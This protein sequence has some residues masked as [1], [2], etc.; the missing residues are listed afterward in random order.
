MTADYK[1]MRKAAR[2]PERTVPICFRGDLIADYEALDRELTKLKKNAGDSLDSGAGAVLEQMDAVEAEMAE[3]TYLVRLRAMT[4]ADYNALVAKHPPRR[5]DDG[6][7]VDDDKDLGVDV[8][9]FWAPFI[10]ASI[11][12]PPLPTEADWEEFVAGIT[13]YQYGLLGNTAF[14]LNRGSVDIPFSLAA[15]TM[16]R[17]SGGE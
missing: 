10:R 1:A 11:I 4:F 17:P 15:S 13:D 9:G 3:N 14:S 16:K 12:D 2:L 6:Q 8:A 7:I 5:D